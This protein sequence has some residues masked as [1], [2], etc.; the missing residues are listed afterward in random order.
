MAVTIAQNPFVVG[1]WVR[2]ENFFGREE[3]IAELLQS[4][5]RAVWVAALR[6]MG[7]TSLLRE[8]ERR[9]QH[10][11]ATPFLPLYWDCEGA[12]DEAT[13]RESLLAALDESA[14]PFP[15][16]PS[17][18]KF[19]TPEILRKVQ[20]AV[21]A[22]KHTLLLLCDEVEALLTVA[23]NDP[24]LLARLRRVLQ[25]E[26]VRCVL[27]ATRRLAQLETFD[28]AGTSPFLHGFVPPLYLAPWTEA[29]AI[30]FLAQTGFT[31]ETQREL[32][33]KSGGHP[34]VLQ[35]LAKRTLELGA[36]AAAY[37]HLQ[38][39]A[40]LHSFFAVDWNTLQPAEQRLLLQ[41][42]TGAACDTVSTESRVALQTLAALGLLTTRAGQWHVRLPLFQAWLVQTQAAINFRTAVLVPGSLQIG[43]RVG[44]YEI[45]REIGRGG[46]GVVYRGRDV[47]LQRMAAIKV[48]HE[49]LLLEPHARARFLAE[50]R[51]ASLFHHP[52]VAAIYGIEFKNDMPCLCMEYIEGQRLDR[53]AKTSEAT[54]ARKLVI[55]KQLAS[56][57][58]AAHAI[59]LIHRDL[60]PGNIIV[61]NDGAAKLLDFG[62]ARRLSHATR[63]TQ[64]GQILGTLA[65]MSPEQVSKL[66][67]DTRSDVFSLGV[68]L[69][70]L[71]AGQ[72]AFVGENELALAYSIVNETPPPLPSSVPHALADLLL[73]MLAKLPEQ[74]PMNGQEVSLLLEGISG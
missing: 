34:F 61:R 54:F 36:L 47:H 59:P 33:A 42:A 50:A 10:D 45:V 68:V 31:A 37:E 71:F 44:A 13:L 55:A 48:L 63:L 23:K 4:P 49:E 66:E 69:Y 22:R 20:Q 5:R 74:R 39:E 64:A 41:C 70:E 19:S 29:E 72:P 21:R 32:Y 43:E 11:D 38:N 28:E 9:V 24:H 53:W 1:Q 35:L 46:M 18:E 27:T 51:A 3:I 57:L 2:G 30:C 60:K 67:L 40:T 17:W 15:E 25:G 6:R 12:A 65:Y 26:H 56:A 8:M 52:H 14:H 73:R 16:Q 58:G 7:K 62:I